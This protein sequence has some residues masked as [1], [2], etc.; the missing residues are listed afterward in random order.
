ARRSAH[1]EKTCGAIPGPKKAIVRNLVQHDLDRREIRPHARR[2]RRPQVRSRIETGSGTMSARTTTSRPFCRVARKVSEPPSFRPPRENVR[3]VTVEPNKGSP[4]AM[5]LFMTGSA[6]VKIP[7][8][9]ALRPA[10][11][12]TIPAELIAGSRRDEKGDAALFVVI[13]VKGAR[14]PVV[15]IVWRPPGS[16]PRKAITPAELMAGEIGP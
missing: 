1:P 13:V 7:V 4:T 15:A 6:P 9:P 3:L 2:P 14:K 12:A 11:N 16:W 10:W 8:P 5:T